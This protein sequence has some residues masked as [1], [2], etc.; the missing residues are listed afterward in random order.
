MSQGGLDTHLGSAPTALADPETDPAPSPGTAPQ[1]VAAPVDPAEPGRRPPLRLAAL[2]PIV[3]L[4]GPALYTVYHYGPSGRSLLIFGGYVT[5]LV[6]LPGIL[7]WRAARRRSVSLAADLGPGLATGYTL[8]VLAYLA[9]RAVGQPL[10]VVVPQVGVLVVFVAVPRLRRYWRAAPGTAPVPLGWLWANAAIVAVVLTWAGL[11]FLRNYRPDGAYNSADMQFHLALIGEL[12]HH[13]PPRVPWVHGEPLSYHWFVYAD[14]AAT[15]WVTGIRPSALLL[16]LYFLPLLA[17]FPFALG[18][19]A[20]RLTGRWWPGPVAAA[21]TLFSQAPYPYGWPLASRSVSNGLGAVDSGVILR[22]GLFS[23]PTQT[24]AALLAV[25]LLLIAVELLRGAARGWPAWVLFAGLVVAVSGAKATYLPIILC[26]LLLIVAVTRLS[27]GGWNRP[28]VRATVIVAAALVFAQLV[29]FDRASQGMMVDPLASL[30]RYGLGDATGLGSS[31]YGLV[32]TTGAGLAVITAVTLLAWLLIWGGVGGLVLRGRWRDPAYLL[33]LGMSAAAL[34][35]VLLLEHYAFSQTWFLVAGRPYLALLAAAGLAALISARRPLGSRP[36]WW[37]CAATIAGAGIVWTIHR[38]GPG[39]TPTVDAVGEPAVFTAIAVPNLALVAAVA[40][41]GGLVF[42]I[43]R[44]AC[45]AL[46]VVVAVAAGTALPPTAQM[47][48]EHVRQAVDAGFAVRPPREP[49]WPHG[50]TAAAGWLRAHSSADDLIATNAHCQRPRLSCG[51]MH[52]WF[53]AFAERRFLVEGW[54]YTP[55]SNRMQA[56]TGLPGAMVPFWDPALLAVNDAAFHRPSGAT[57]AELRDR[58][59]V[60]WLF[61]DG[62]DPL[63]RPGALDRFAQP[64]YRAGDVTIYR[65]RE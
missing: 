56:R 35:A 57:V 42:L 9:A 55:S 54:G 62:T 26:G 34:A 28:A 19:L 16:D 52:F 17:A 53:S 46:A 41:V 8:T 22:N 38:L 6:A 40:V 51:N 59:G 7:L 50:T 47:I 45:A 10:G 11:Y 63:V 14:L 49:L 25:G 36:G 4:G 5:V 23:S 27:G 18:A 43:R 48:G 21:I 61:V 2:L 44:Q 37:L 29:L 30:S 1:P 31:R 15:T 64:R 13:M 32:T 24:F 60:R 58:Y 12:R 33:L 65:L 39:T 3:L 20:H